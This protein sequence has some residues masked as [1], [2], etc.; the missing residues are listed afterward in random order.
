MT[1]PSGAHTARHDETTDPA[2]YAAAVRS[3][4]RDLPAESV[5]ELTDGLEADLA[6]QAR[7]SSTTD[8]TR[9]VGPARDYAQELRLSAGLPRARPAW[10]SPGE[11][12][13]ATRRR[14][15]GR[16]A[17]RPW[18]PPVRAGLVSLA[19]AWWLVR[20]WIA[21]RLLWAATGQ[22]SGMFIGFLVLAALSVALGRGWLRQHRATRVLVLAGNV[23]AVPIGLLLMA[24]PGGILHAQ[25]AGSDSS[26]MASPQD[27]IYTNGSQVRNIFAY[28]RDGRP[29]SGIQL[30][31]QDGRPIVLDDDQRELMRQ[32]D[33]SPDTAEPDGSL[34][35]P[36]L[37]AKGSPQYNVFPQISGHGGQDD[38]TDPE[39]NP[40]P[41]SSTPQP[42]SLSV[43]ALPRQQVDPVR[44]PGSSSAT[45]PLRT[46]PPIVTGTAAVGSTLGSR[47]TGWTPG[48]RLT[49]RWYRDGRA[50]PGATHDHYR[51][52]AAD[53]GR[54][55]TVTVTGERPGYTTTAATSG[56]TAAV[57]PHQG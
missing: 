34:I 51:V 9:L 23:L 38:G 13:A 30:F 35:Y 19:P 53:R 17:T 32:G 37:D 33:T 28:S 36:Y 22:H 5:E 42:G 15:E 56:P 6:E 52:T 1:I 27:G 7:E 57:R 31:D 48:P 12:M 41:E 16:L 10:R 20:A 24:E 26:Q 45:T 11:G 55:L 4:L 46:T 25:P 39:G 14:F 43:P 18:W 21:T 54:R 8:L 2:H 29:V 49:Y 47:V 50:I 3:H 40:L 44:S